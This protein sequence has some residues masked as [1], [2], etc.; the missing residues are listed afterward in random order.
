MPGFWPS[1]GLVSNR[2]T[3]KVT[4]FDS[5]TRKSETDERSIDGAVEMKVTFGSPVRITITTQL[6]LI[7]TNNNFNYLKNN[8]FN[9]FIY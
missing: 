3:A 2:V 6:R 7:R 8:I 4:I 1:K 9:S 5:W